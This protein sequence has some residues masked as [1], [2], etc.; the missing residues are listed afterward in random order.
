MKLD[1]MDLDG[2]LSKQVAWMVQETSQYF[3]TRELLVLCQ[4]VAIIRLTQT[5]AEIKG[6]LDLGQIQQALRE[7]Q[8]GQAAGPRKPPAAKSEGQRSKK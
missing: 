5:L 6:G 4:T 2:W 7:A 3:D 8:G 1:D